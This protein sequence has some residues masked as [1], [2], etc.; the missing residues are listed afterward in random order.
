VHEIGGE[1]QPMSL[2]TSSNTSDA[3]FPLILCTRK[4]V[5]RFP[6]EVVP[7]GSGPV[8]LGGAPGWMV[9]C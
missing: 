3:S 2:L 8:T 1:R 4:R 5:E 6:P 7:I 9:V